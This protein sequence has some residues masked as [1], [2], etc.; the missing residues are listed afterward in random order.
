MYDKNPFEILDYHHSMVFDHVRTSTFLRA[1]LRTVKPGD[2][3]LDIGSGTGILSL[4]ACLAGARHVYAIEQGPVIEIARKIV[5]QNGYQERVTFIK[6]WSSN[7]SLPERVDVLITETIGN[8]GFE[9][10][11]LGWVIDARKRLLVQGGTIVPQMIE[12]IAV[13]VESNDDSDYVDGWLQ[14]VYSFDFSAAHIVSANNLH[15]IKLSPESFLSEPARLAS[16]KLATIE[17]EEVRGE[18]SFLITR[19]GQLH[20]IGGW[21]SA[22][23]IPGIELSNAMP[24]KTPSWTHGYLPLNKPIQVN[25]GDVLKV[26]IHAKSNAAQ[27]DW[28]VKLDNNRIQAIRSS[29]DFH[30]TSQTTLIGQLLPEVDPKILNHTPARSVEAEVD[31]FILRLMDGNTPIGEIARQTA[32]SFPTHFANIESTQYRVQRVC[33]YYERWMTC[34]ALSQNSQPIYMEAQK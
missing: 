16:V 34:T 19:D 31:L 27:W 4:F 6:E 14:D 2:V 17:S 3:V 1:I 24:E 30:I 9:E 33:E 7:A 25:A 21:F 8:I 29:N 32:E 10:G 23:L 5:R 20:G 22:V 18:T 13:P 12:L 11:I 28:Q 26:K 15:W